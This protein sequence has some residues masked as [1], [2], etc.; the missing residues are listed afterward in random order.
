MRFSY[1]WFLDRERKRINLRGKKSLS[2]MIVYVDTHLGRQDG[3]D[4]AACHKY[5]KLIWDQLKPG[6]NFMSKDSFQ[7][8]KIRVNVNGRFISKKYTDW[9]MEE[10]KK[11]LAKHKETGYQGNGKDK[12]RQNHTPGSSST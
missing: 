9:S 5:Y 11:L 10:L 7:P 8:A 2:N 3:K 4:A 6:P 1:R 12:R